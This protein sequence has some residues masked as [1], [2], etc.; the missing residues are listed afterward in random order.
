MQDYTQLEEA[1]VDIF[2]LTERLMNNEA[3]IT[4][5]MNRFVENE[6]Y[7]ALKTAI[8]ASDWKA[9]CEASHMLKGM[10]GNLSITELFRL[11]SQQ[12]VHFRSGEN[13]MACLLMTEIEAKY[14][15]TINH[16]HNWLSE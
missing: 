6:S 16:I 9:A 8:K 11:F 4:R 15:N 12:V 14:E 7:R 2:T 1:G 13:E 3:L 10:C 5:F